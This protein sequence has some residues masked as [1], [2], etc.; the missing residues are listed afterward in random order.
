MTKPLSET[1]NNSFITN[2][3]RSFT[4]VEKFHLKLDPTPQRWGSSVHFPDLGPVINR[5]SSMATVV[6]ELE[7]RDIAE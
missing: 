3:L 5:N 2:R 1:P 4:G 7:R 6:E